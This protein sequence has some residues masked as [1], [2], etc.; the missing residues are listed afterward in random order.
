MY[1]ISFGK[2]HIIVIY[3]SLVTRDSHEYLAYII[4]PQ[5]PVPHE[6]AAPITPEPPSQNPDT[7]SRLRELCEPKN[8]YKKLS[9]IFSS[10]IFTDV[11]NPIIRMIN[12]P[13]NAYLLPPN[14]ALLVRSLRVTVKFCLQMKLTS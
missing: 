4:S 3:Q 13:I 11:I 12:E 6:Y 1:F 5:S 8:H 9:S 10:L 14:Q 2:K 7:A